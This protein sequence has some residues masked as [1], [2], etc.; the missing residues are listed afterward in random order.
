[1]ERRKF[2][3]IGSWAI[4]LASILPSS[5]VNLISGN[6]AI[7][8]A[9][10]KREIDFEDPADY[11][12]T[13]SSIL[14]TLAPDRI[15]STVGYNNEISGQI[16]R[17]K[18]GKRVTIDLINDTDTPDQVHWHGQ[19]SPDTVDG[20][21]EE[22]TPYVPARRKRRISFIP[23]PSGT[24]F[25]HTHVRAGNDLNKGAYTG[26]DAIVYIEAE[27][28]KKEDYDL[29]EFFMLKEFEPFFT[30][31]EEE[32]EEGGEDREENS[33]GKPNGLEVG[34]RSFCINGKTMQASEPIKVQSGERVLFQFINV[35]ATENRK[36]ALP[37]H[38]FK[39]V[40]LDRN[41]VP[42][43]PRSKFWN[44]GLPNV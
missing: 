32:E 43:Q 26:Q 24:R 21:A 33:N 29:E 35:S 22:G 4:P 38:R 18:E 2:I 27:E 5:A 37:G 41:P 34:Y 44:W 16:I 28:E 9:D 11:T 3:Q 17:F 20:S 19:F 6:T 15:I 12:L 25:V 1:M 42:I 10:E 31:F 36:I 23:G 40:A 30:N 13:I 14:A 7:P 39:V 8:G